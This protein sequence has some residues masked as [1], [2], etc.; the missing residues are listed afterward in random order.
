ME[1]DAATIE[2]EPTSPESE[3]GETDQASIATEIP[4]EEPKMKNE[5]QS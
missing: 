5:A 4:P 2:E 3:S 1:P